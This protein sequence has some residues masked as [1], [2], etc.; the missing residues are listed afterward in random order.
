[1]SEFDPWEDPLEEEMATYSSILAWRLPWTCGSQPIGSQRVGHDWSDFAKR[2]QS[3]AE[4]LQHSRVPC[5]CRIPEW[6]GSS[7]LYLGWGW[8][9]EFTWKLTLRSTCCSLL[10][11]STLFFWPRSSL[12]HIPP[13]RWSYMSVCICVL[14]LGTGKPCQAMT[15]KRKGADCHHAYSQ[16]PD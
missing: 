2:Q 8:S 1:M 12:G 3:G 13:Y 7:L 14:V 4:Q 9:G 5:V 16:I 11:S 10:W 15:G 6:Q